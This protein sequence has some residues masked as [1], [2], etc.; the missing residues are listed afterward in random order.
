MKRIQ[1]IVALAVLMSLPLD[2]WAQAPVNV[3][4]VTT[5][6]GYDFFVTWLLNG[7]RGP[8]D[9]DLKLQLLINSRP[10]E[11]HPEI[12]T[13]QVRVEYSNGQGADY[14]V[15]VGETTVIDVTQGDV[16]YIDPEKN[17]A[18][19]ISDKG[20]HVYSKNG[21][22][23]TVYAG[24]KIGIR[25]VAVGI[26]AEICVIPLLCSVI[27]CRNDNTF[28]VNSVVFSSDFVNEKLISHDLFLLS[29]IVCFELT[30]ATVHD[31]EATTATALDDP[32]FTLT[33]PAAAINIIPNLCGS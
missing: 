21:V 17:E 19:K 15:P 18:E 6:E 9:K 25:V 24:N 3:T 26:R 27:G 12:T 16:V 29:F 14:Q 20:V 28:V 11:G 10:V 33:I 23:M 32:G 8:K 7:N 1:W 31:A 22:K 13:N 4:P 5:T 2:N 30:Q